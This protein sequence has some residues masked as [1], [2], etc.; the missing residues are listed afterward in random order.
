MAPNI[1]VLELF[2]FEGRLMKSLGEIVMNRAAIVKVLPLPATHDS[3]N[4]RRAAD[5]I[6][7]FVFDVLVAGQGF[8]DGWREHLSC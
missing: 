1:I 2:K 7:H 8:V 5:G 6:W 4:E 3:D